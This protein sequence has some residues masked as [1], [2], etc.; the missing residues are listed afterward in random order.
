M[1]VTTGHPI[2]FSANAP[3]DIGRQD[4]RIA[5]DGDQIVLGKLRKRLK[6]LRWLFVL[7]EHKTS[8]SP[9]LIAGELWRLVINIR[10]RSEIL[11]LLKLSPFADIVQNNP[12]FAFKYL[13]PNYL[14][15]GFT[16]TECASCFLY[17]YR[18][19]YA[20]LPEITLRQILQ[21]HIAL[22]EIADGSDRLALTMGLSEPFGDK[23]GELSLDLVVNGEKVFN[24]SFTIVPGWVVKSKAAEILLI[25]RIQGRSGC[26]SQIKLARKAFHEFFPR[27]LLFSATQGIAE[28]IGICEL[29]AI[30]ATKQRA[31]LKEYSAIFKDSYDDFFAQ[32]GMVETS[33]GFY[34]CPIPLENRPLAS[35]KRGKRSRARRRRTIRE[36]IR[37]ASAGLVM[38]VADRAG[39]PSDAVKSSAVP[40]P[41]GS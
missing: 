26:R 19:L 3:T 25:T 8:W 29:G 4:P 31:Y 22:Y 14:V 18:R 11:N 15:R 33:T 20:A 13:V 38:G 27:K 2:R 5:H 1:G 28:A 16:G 7:A 41:F 17:H 39:S 40:T 37:S 9:T 12:G 32:M 21:G 35:L 34:S 6:I 36:Q 24:L 23:E 30:C 10:K